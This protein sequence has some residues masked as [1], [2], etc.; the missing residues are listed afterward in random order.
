LRCGIG[1]SGVMRDQLHHLT[2]VGSLPNVSMGVVPMRSDRMRWPAEGFWIFDSTQVNVELISGYLTIT[3][4]S[5]IQLY[6]ETFGELAELAVHGA[7]ARE[8][9]TSAAALLG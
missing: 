4:P 7:A 1:G 2:T 3:Q 8:L 6:A 5:E 9:I